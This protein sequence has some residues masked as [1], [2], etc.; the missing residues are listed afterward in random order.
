M[1]IEETAAAAHDLDVA[2]L[3]HPGEPARELADD[4]F[5]PTAEFVEVD[6]ARAETHPVFRQCG[7]LIGD[8]GDVQQ[9]LDRVYPFLRFD[10]IVVVHHAHNFLREAFTDLHRG[11]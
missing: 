5:L 11:A 8:G 10:R 7:H 3:R 2:R 4:R 1:R 6:L 9:R